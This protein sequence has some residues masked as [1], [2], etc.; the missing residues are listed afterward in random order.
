MWMYVFVTI[1]ACCIVISC[2]NKNSPPTYLGLILR[3][4]LRKKS[5]GTVELALAAMQ[6]GQAH[7]GWYKLDGAESGEVRL[8]IT[9]TES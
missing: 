6:D 3:D 1:I 8:V 9:Y 2:S 5:L 7:E 4:L